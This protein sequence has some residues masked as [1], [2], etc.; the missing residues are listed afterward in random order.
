MQVQIGKQ[1]TDETVVKHERRSEAKRGD[2]GR[3]H[4][5][6][7]WHHVEQQSYRK[8]ARAK[9]EPLLGHHARTCDSLRKKQSQCKGEDGTLLYCCT[10]LR[11]TGHAMLQIGSWVQQAQI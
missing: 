11:P 9:T 5:L 2:A 6:R 8:P 4:Q 1:T 7:M 3:L 10:E